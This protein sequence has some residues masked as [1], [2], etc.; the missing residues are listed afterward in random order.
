MA[1]WAINQVGKKDVPVD[2][3]DILKGASDLQGTNQTH[4]REQARTINLQASPTDSKAR[5]LITSFQDPPMPTST[6]NTGQELSGSTP[7]LK[8]ENPEMVLRPEGHGTID[9]LNKEQNQSPGR[10]LHVRQGE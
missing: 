1:P 9:K 4:Q 3:Y 2:V 10:K 5:Y 7:R 8:Q 6:R